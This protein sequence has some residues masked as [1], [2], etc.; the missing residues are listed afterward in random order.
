M[1]LV[2]VL[3]FSLAVLLL[4][5]LFANILPQVQSD[6][7]SEEVFAP[8]GTLDK[9]G[10]AAWGE[11][12]FRGKGTCTLCHNNLGRAPDLLKLNLAVVL[13]GRLKDKR[14]K[15]K[16]AG[17]SGAKAIEIYIRESLLDPSAYVV[18]GF[19][20]KG[21]GDRLSPMR[22]ADKPPVGLKAPEID[23][24]IAFLQARAG[25]EITVALP[26]AGAKTSETTAKKSGG[27]G[28]DDEDKLAKTAKAA[29]EKYTCNGCHDLFGSEA[30]AGPRLGGVGKRLG[31]DGL[32]KAILDPNAAIAKGFE[33]DLMPKDY[34]QKMRISELALILDYLIKLEGKKSGAK[35]K[36]KE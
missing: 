25:F 16:A 13:P 28:E 17:K 6:P 8:T 21:S 23:A 29:I 5:T 27:E 12:V 34:A 14:Y 31:A 7:P 15:G 26:K 33:R 10:L 3:G 22:P 2:R 18:A 19:G 4:Y 35:E 30:D 24:V 32:R 1:T 11:R 20:K 36:A 9:A